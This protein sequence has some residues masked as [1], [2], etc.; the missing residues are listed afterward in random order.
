VTKVSGKRSKP[1]PAPLPVPLPV[2]LQQKHD[3][4]ERIR[5]A[6]LELF[7][8]D[9]FGATTTKAVAERAGVASGT[10]FVHAPDK[11]DLLFL[12]MHD[13]IASVVDTAFDTLPASAPLLEQLLHLF[14]AVIRAYAKNPDVALAFVKALPGARGPN[15]QRVD[16][17]TFAFLHRVAALVRAAQEQGTFAPDV[18]PL[19][20]AQNAFALYFF[21]VLSSLSG[22]T[23]FETAIDPHLRLSLELQLRGLTLP[24]S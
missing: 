11:E 7:T 5:V 9:G 3:T 24:R 13:E 21:A 2:R 15:G 18:P 19:L 6:A 14:G 17:L 22:Y 12:V 10:V 23:S 16:A 1:A 20:L 4:R 8:R